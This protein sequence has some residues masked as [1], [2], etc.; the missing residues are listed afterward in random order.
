M[1][2]FIVSSLYF[3]L[4]GTYIFTQDTYTILLIPSISYIYDLLYEKF[5]LFNLSYNLLYIFSLCQIKLNK[6]IKQHKDN[7]IVIE[8]FKD[9]KL[10]NCFYLS[11]YS[12]INDIYDQVDKYNYKIVSLHLDEKIFKCILTNERKL[13]FISLDNPLA[14]FEESN[15]RF[16]SIIVKYNEKQITINLKDGKNNYYIVNNEIDKQ[17]VQYYLE[18]ILGVAIDKS[19]FKYNIVLVDDNVNFIELTDE[20]SIIIQKDNYIIN[21]KK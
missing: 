4:Y 6:L 2:L 10:D 3:F 19:N 14:G 20:D 5:T 18:N 7:D 13:E 17:F 11:D 1:F 21:L 16:V 9:G 8:C 15:I 12:D